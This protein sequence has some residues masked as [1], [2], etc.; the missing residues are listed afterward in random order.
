VDVPRANPPQFIAW[1]MTWL[2]RPEPGISRC[3]SSGR[4]MEIT[5]IFWEKATAVHVYSL[6]GE[7]GLAHR[8]SRHLHDLAR[9]AQA[10]HLD[11]AIRARNV[12]ATVANHKSKFFREKAADGSVIDY[13]KAV[14]GSL[15]L[16][17]QGSAL[18]ALREDYQAIMQEGLLLEDAEEFDSLIARC[19]EIQTIVNAA[20]AK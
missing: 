1:N 15:V 19:Q 4:A 7:H 17:P 8:F 20:I 5:R 6:Q 12:S 10:G 18:A 11:G 9:L 3:R 13:Q 16:V 2:A 14:N